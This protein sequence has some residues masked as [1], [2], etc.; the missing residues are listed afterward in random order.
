MR[1]VFLF[2]Y[3][4]SVVRLCF[5]NM[6]RKIYALFLL[7]CFGVGGIHNVRIHRHFESF[8]AYLSHIRSPQHTNQHKII[9]HDKSEKDEETGHSHL[10]FHRHLSTANISEFIKVSFEITIFKQLFYA[11]ALTLAITYLESSNKV[12][13]IIPR[14]FTV[15]STPNRRIE[16]KRGPPRIS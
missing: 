8:G 15:N 11:N 13:Y 4:K 3:N 5:V 12:R 1:F 9:Q 7:L 6:R 14:I 10:P 2:F 16:N